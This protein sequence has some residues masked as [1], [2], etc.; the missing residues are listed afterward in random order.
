MPRRRRRLPF[1]DVADWSCAHTGPTELERRLADKP[2]DLRD[3]V[4][5]APGVRRRGS[6]GEDRQLAAP[7][8]RRINMEPPSGR[9][10]HD[11]A[12]TSGACRPPK[13]NA[14]RCGHVRP[15]RRL[16]GVDAFSGEQGGETPAR[17]SRRAT[18]S[19]PTP[20]V[21]RR[22]LVHPQDPQ[23]S[24]RTVPAETTRTTDHG[25]QRRARPSAGVE[26]IQEPSA[27][28][29]GRVHSGPCGRVL[30]LK[31][32]ESKGLPRR[33]DGPYASCPC[34]RGAS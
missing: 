15:R 32:S 9:D 16:W 18:G 28:R 26:A 21:R 5:H 3:L 33:R 30:D 14:A 27:R 24:L 10:R 19:R 17:R 6:A 13:I 23:T 34:V 12:G 8:G 1:G 2:S 29:S 25:P 22:Q 31:H 4:A 11:R 7:A 20:S